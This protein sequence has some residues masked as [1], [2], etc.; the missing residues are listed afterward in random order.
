MTL[1]PIPEIRRRRVELQKAQERAQGQ[2][3]EGRRGQPDRPGQ[4]HYSSAIA[5]HP[6]WAE[7]K[8]L[9]VQGRV[10]G[11]DKNRVAP[12]AWYD[13]HD[14]T[15]LDKSKR[16]W[17]K[18]CHV[19]EYPPIYLLPAN[20]PLLL[21]ANV[22]AV[23]GQLVRYL[24]DSQN[25]G[26]ASLWISGCFGQVIKDW[27]VAGRHWNLSQNDRLVS[28]QADLRLYDAEVPIDVTPS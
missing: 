3:Q 4:A 7:F 8:C 20:S 17:K 27:S 23:Q 12:E 25:E 16:A 13:Q 2:R 18:K 26:A 5:Q 19:D 6:S 24:P 21:P 28:S 22:G 1:F 15:W 9:P 11:S 14:D 10:K